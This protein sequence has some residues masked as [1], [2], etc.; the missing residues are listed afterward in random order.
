MTTQERKEVIETM[1]PGFEAET[2]PK[3]GFFWYDADR[4]F[5]IGVMKIPAFS[6]QF[7]GNGKKTIPILHKDQ[8]IQE[9]KRARQFGEA[10][11][12]F[13]NRDYTEVPRG[14]V[15]EYKNSGFK[16]LTGSWINE[17]PEARQMIVS[18]FTLESAP[19]EF[20]QDEHRDI[21]RGWSDEFT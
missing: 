6:L 19:V 15:F 10:A 1:M 18:E 9:R 16:I 17:H 14:R 7:N 13:F 21:G 12:A 2:A 5:L 4:Q 8:W 11:T 3:V 20:I